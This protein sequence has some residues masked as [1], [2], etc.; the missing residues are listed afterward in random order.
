MKPT[1]RLRLTLVY[2]GLFLVTAAVLIGVAYAFVLN[3][4]DQPGALTGEVRRRIEAL[5]PEA[6]G[7]LDRRALR[8]LAA[9]IRDDAIDDA[10]DELLRQSLIAF[11]L[12]AV[13]SI[14]LAW[15]LAGRALGPVHRLADSAA[16][17]D[18]GALEQGITVAGPD[19]EVRR[20][21]ATLDDLFRRLGTAFSAQRRFSADASHELRSPLARLRA[22]ADLVADDP[23][24]SPEA[25]A[26]ATSVRADVIDAEGMV[27]ALLALSRAESGARADEP[28]D[29]ADLTGEA[30][31]ELTDE[32]DARGITME[33]RLADAPTT[34][35]P[36]LLRRAVANVVRNAIDHNRPGGTVEIRVGVSAETAELVVEN[37]GALLAPEE[38]ERA[39][40]PF[41]RLEGRT[42]AGGH[43]LGL[44]LVAAVVAAHDGRVEAAPRAGGGLRLVISLPPR[45]PAQ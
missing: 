25:R 33:L 13:P 39:F 41:H 7:S 31:G 28:V 42:N 12:V 36:A 38:V 19:D 4:V 10:T 6:L 2:A 16:S 23:S 22:R 9:E 32:A 35:D 5:G 34:G 11:G 21:A 15:H 14:A 20:L 3:S 24:A 37:T 45:R 8:E 27:D 44:A 40:E 1:I 18:A 26:L 43:G 29:L 17:V 30:V